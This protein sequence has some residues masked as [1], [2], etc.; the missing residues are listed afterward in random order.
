MFHIHDISKSEAIDLLQ[1]F[2]LDDRGYIKNVY[3]ENQY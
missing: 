3:R 2:V 1:N